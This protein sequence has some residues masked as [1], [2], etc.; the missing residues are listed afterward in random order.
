MVNFMKKAAVIVL[1]DPK[2]RSEES[3]GVYST[4]WRRF[5]ISNNAATMFNFYFKARERAGRANSPT[6]SIRRTSFSQ[7]SRIKWPGYRAAVPMFSAREKARRI[8]KCCS[9]H[10][11]ITESGAPY[12]RRPHGFDFLELSVQR[13]AHYS[14][15]LDFRVIEWLR[16]ILKSL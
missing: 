2:T 12:K 3:L 9:E 4:R 8:A 10:Q 1:S 5:M 14:S 15:P 11:R 16:I 6:R 13:R 7:R